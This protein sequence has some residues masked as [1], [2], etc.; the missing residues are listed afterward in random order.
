MKSTP[1]EFFSSARKMA[2]ATQ[3]DELPKQLTEFWR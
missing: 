2:L 1:G 3:V